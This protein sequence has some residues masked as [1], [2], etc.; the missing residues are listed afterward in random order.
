MFGCR[1]GGSLV[2]V[3]EWVDG[4]GLGLDNWWL[5]MVL[6][7]KRCGCV[8]VTVLG[9]LFILM[10]RRTE[11]RTREPDVCAKKTQDE[12][13]DSSA[14]HALSRS[15]EEDHTR[16][17][18]VC[19]DIERVESVARGWLYHTKDPWVLNTSQSLFEGLFSISRSC[20]QA[21]R[22]LD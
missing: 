10:S 14:C 3:S 1:G 8:M 12:S 17:L 22:I 19:S 2:V 7:D 16:P 11:L 9:W 13:L 6:R 4:I 5:G 20:R 18:I 15:C 21:G